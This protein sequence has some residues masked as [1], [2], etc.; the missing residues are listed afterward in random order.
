MSNPIPSPQDDASILR[1]LKGL[2][3]LLLLSNVALGLF[4]FYFLRGIDRKYSTLINDTVPTL[5]D[6]QGL[7]VITSEAM[8]GTNPAFM[9]GTSDEVRTEF[10][11]HGHEALDRERQMRE[12]ILSSPWFA[13]NE[14][15][16]ENL[17]QVGQTFDTAAASILDLLGAGKMDDANR[18]REKDL[19]PA[20][21]RYVVTTRES[22]QHAHTDSLRTSDMITLKS[23]NLSRLLLG[24]GSWPIIMLGLFLS[25]LAILVVGVLLNVFLRR[26]Q[27]L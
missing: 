12:R 17:R 26:E 2:V 4:A 14:S 7:T 9:P 3:V 25:I 1:Q 19:R 24:L 27:S 6:L 11:K 20:Y 8:H 15:E 10:V 13:T 18:A 21:E 22:T 16:R 23:G 5:N